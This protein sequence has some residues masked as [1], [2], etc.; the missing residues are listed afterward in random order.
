M[1]K[2]RRPRLSLEALERRENPI[3]PVSTPVNIVFN[4]SL[5]I[6][7][8]GLLTVT[9]QSSNG[10]WLVQ[11]GGSTKG[12]YNVTGGIGITTP[13]SA[14]AVVVQFA[15]NQK[16]LPGNLSIAAGNAA[17]SLSVQGATGAFLGGSLSIDSGY[18][19]DSIAIG[20]VAGL[21]VGGNTVLTGDYGTNTLLLGSDTSTSQ[22]RGN[23]NIH[24]VENITVGGETTV[25]GNSTIDML[26]T[27]TSTNSVFNPLNLA[28]DNGAVLQGSLVVTGSALASNVEFN[29]PN[30]SF[31]PTTVNFGNS[32]GN[33]LNLNATFNGNVTFNSAPFG[34]TSLTLGN[35]LNVQSTLKQAGNLTMNMGSGQNFYSLSGAFNVTGAFVLNAAADSSNQSVLLIGTIG[36]AANVTFGNGSVDL[37]SIET[38]GGP[39]TFNAGSGNNT[40]DLFGSYSAVNY[41]TTTGDNN[42]FVEQS[43]TFTGTLT[44]NT[45]AGSN[46]ANLQV[47]ANETLNVALT[48]SSGGVGANA[49]LVIIDG[50]GGSV[51]TGSI[52]NNTAEE[53]NRF[54]NSTSQ[55][56]LM[57]TGLYFNGSNTEDNT[58]TSNPYWIDWG[59][60]TA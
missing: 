4:G 16:S 41:D 29:G 7:G 49:P 53:G 34:G 18:G 3:S 28:F 51:V 56:Q 26:Q 39:F 52:V 47:N 1:R 32:G 13:N 37:L 58:P 45:G 43:A 23:L 21:T 15:N 54:R 17:D 35:N 31:G 6:T 44:W 5:F 30:G 8:G 19:N 27:P 55:S 22:F 38:I 57:T 59:T 60:N 40:L 2:A 25:R 10:Y 46:F 33:V 36:G 12:I 11:D 24:S 14:T 48:F 9:Q 20:T 42:L 50:N